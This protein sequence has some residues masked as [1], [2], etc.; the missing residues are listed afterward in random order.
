MA[1]GLAASVF[2]LPQGIT[3]FGVLSNV[4]PGATSSLAAHAATK[5]PEKTR[6]DLKSLK[7]GGQEMN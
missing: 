6:S 7:F 1:A 2:L 3:P 5:K 4:G